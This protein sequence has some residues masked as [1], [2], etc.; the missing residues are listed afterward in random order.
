[1]ERQKESE[2]EEGETVQWVLSECVRVALSLASPFFPIQW[3]LEQILTCSLCICHSQLFLPS[4]LLSWLSFHIFECMSEIR[5]EFPVQ[6]QRICTRASHQSVTLCQCITMTRKA[7]PREA[8]PLLL[9]I[10]Y[11]RHIVWR[12]HILQ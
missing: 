3:L 8:C 5:A 9:G 4:S 12:F 11:S 7:H 2:N 6:F 1:M 10:C